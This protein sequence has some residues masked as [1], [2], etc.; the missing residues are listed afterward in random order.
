MTSVNSGDEAPITRKEVIEILNKV[1]ARLERYIT[2]TLLTKKE[3]SSFERTLFALQDAGSNI[4]S[5]LPSNKNGHKYSSSKFK[6]GQTDLTQNWNK[7]K[8][9]V[10]TIQIKSPEQLCLDVLPDSLRIMG[11]TFSELIDSIP[12]SN[13]GKY[14][15]LSSQLSD[16]C[17]MFERSTNEFLES[18]RSDEDIDNE[19]H[20]YKKTISSYR[21][22]LF[23]NFEQLFR[24]KALTTEDKTTLISAH[25]DKMIE[26]LLTLGTDPSKDLP[27]TII[28]C[29]DYLK[30]LLND[31]ENDNPTI[32]T[33][34][35]GSLN[36]VS[37]T[38]QLSSKVQSIKSQK[39]PRASIISRE[40]ES[41]DLNSSIVDDEQQVSNLNDD[42]SKT[43]KENLA[44]E[45]ELR[46]LEN[47]KDNSQSL[48]QLIEEYLKERI[49]K[50][51]NEILEM[52]NRVK[53]KNDELAEIGI[54]FNKEQAEL[55]AKSKKLS[56]EYENL[57][58]SSSSNER[59][60]LIDQ[61]SSL[62]KEFQR[63]CAKLETILSDTKLYQQNTPQLI[64]E[65][66]SL[67]DQTR[68]LKNEGKDLEINLD[69]LQSQSSK[70]SR[71][72]DDIYNQINQRINE[73]MN[74]VSSLKRTKS[75]L[76]DD[77]IQELQENLRITNK[78]LSR[79]SKQLQDMK[80]LYDAARFTRISN[81]FQELV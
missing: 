70:L 28:H 56:E 64:N 32:S 62:S 21:R 81:S 79:I 72:G 5:S 14:I 11:Q 71:Y 26:A 36:V 45:Q 74:Q 58:I 1:V 78:E 69:S 25:L 77:I 52:Q 12:N 61:K 60:Q 2:N 46:D 49:E 48:D 24:V 13:Q 63:V 53:A 65:E 38:K 30:I 9:K 19:I 75:E 66:E 22:H 31:D 41:P 47:Y 33:L 16:S 67:H 23:K 73:E 27:K 35:P 15:D 57:S 76:E 4:I 68:K 80:K 8:L 37:P 44:L 18:I 29:D 50:L 43:E 55:A 17:S 51:N 20:N 34:L 39:S 42:I 40:I 3:K 59:N 10:Y 6:Q 7:F 54:Q